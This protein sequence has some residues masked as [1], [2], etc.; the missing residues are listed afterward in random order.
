MRGITIDHCGTGVRMSG[1]HAD[2][3]GM[4]IIDT[5]T[6]F[7]LSNGATVDM[8][9]VSHEFTKR[10]RASRRPRAANDDS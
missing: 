1:G 9:D 4:R 2:I 10:K 7:D 8:R 6:G 5:P 3:E